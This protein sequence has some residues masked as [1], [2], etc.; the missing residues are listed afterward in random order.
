MQRYS[1]ILQNGVSSISHADG[2]WKLIQKYKE[3]L[4][5]TVVA[6]K[7]EEE[8]KNTLFNAVQEL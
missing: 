2:L 4:E 7:R 1:P 6:S 8:I 3:P 5:D